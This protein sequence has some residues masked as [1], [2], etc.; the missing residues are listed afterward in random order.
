MQGLRSSRKL[1]REILTYE[2]GMVQEL[3]L[4]L[5]GLMF[6]FLFEKERFYLYFVTVVVTL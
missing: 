3:Q 2:W 5:Y 4:L 1:I 6:S